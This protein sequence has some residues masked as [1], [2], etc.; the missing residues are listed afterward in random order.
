MAQ[1]ASGNMII[2]S[3]DDII[4][5]QEYLEACICGDISDN[6]TVVMWAMDGAQLY[7]DKSS[8]CW[9]GIWVILDF[10]P[11]IRYKKIHVL[12]ST[13]IPGP[14]NP[15]IMESFFFPGFHHISAIQTAGFKVW[16]ASENL[17]R[18]S[19]IFFYL[20]KYLSK[21]CHDIIVYHCW[22]AVQMDLEAC[23]LHAWLA[24]MDHS[25]VIYSVVSR[26]GISLVG[27]TTI[28]HC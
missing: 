8:D 2:N 20:G 18:D 19:N 13:F 21:Q 16:D 5:G 9:V 28:Q 25:H 24:T 15:K 11:A 7:H 12:P 17:V 26:A 23:T 27:P 1:I 22:Q 6:D 10:D 14:N 4:H 3:Y